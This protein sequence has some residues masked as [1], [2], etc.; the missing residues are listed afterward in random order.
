MCAQPTITNGSMTPDEAT[1]EY[2]DRYTPVCDAGYNISSTEALVCGGGGV[3][4]PSAP[5]C[6]STYIYDLLN[7]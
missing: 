4:S 3:L 2:G 7:I 1:I 6:T 5:T